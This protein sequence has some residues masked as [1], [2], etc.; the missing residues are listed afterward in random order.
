MRHARKL[1]PTLLALAL[2]VALTACGGDGGNTVSEGVERP[3]DAGGRSGSPNGGQAAS[4]SLPT[5]VIADGEPVG[6]VAE[7]EFS[8]GDRIRFQVE[9]DVDDEV[10]VH[11]YDLSE[12]VTAGGA[13]SFDFPADIEGIFEVEL[14]ERAEPIAEL[15]VNP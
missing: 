3:Q 15:R 12:D 13:A 7:L 6:G 8:A 10:H 4:G 11:G 2:A 1:A 5:I 9:S 14:E